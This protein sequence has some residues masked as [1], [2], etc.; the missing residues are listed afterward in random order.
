MQ[1]K[2]EGLK[3]RIRH[4]Q[5]GGGHEATTAGDLLAQQ[6]LASVAGAGQADI[7]QLLLNPNV[8]AIG[9]VFLILGMLMGKIFF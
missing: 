3:N 8:L 1:L 6:K 7:A 9:L 2:E 5:P 4:R